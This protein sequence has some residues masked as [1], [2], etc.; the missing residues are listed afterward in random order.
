SGGAR[1]PCQRVWRRRAKT[2]GRPSAV[3]GT[4]RTLVVGHGPHRRWMASIKAP[5]EEVRMTTSTLLTNALLI[6]GTGRAAVHGANVLIEGQSIK[7]VNPGPL[8]VPPEV[9]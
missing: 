8:E 1:E 9:K 7:T 6:D 5:R 2:P 3:D 4:L